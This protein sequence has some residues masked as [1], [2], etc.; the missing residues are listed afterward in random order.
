MS[1]KNSENRHNFYD[2]LYGT[3]S[4]GL[5]HYKLYMYILIIYVLLYMYMQVSSV[6]LLSLVRKYEKCVSDFGRLISRPEL[7]LTTIFLCTFR[8]L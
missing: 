4:D 3:G 6:C 5:T 8:T 7:N 2:F 1:Y